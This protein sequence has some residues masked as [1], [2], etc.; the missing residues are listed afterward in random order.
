MPD[1]DGGRAACGGTGPSAGSA[2]GIDR[3]DAGCR[4]GGY[5][6][7]YGSAGP[8]RHGVVDGIDRRQA[9]GADGGFDGTWGDDHAGVYDG[10]D[11]RMTTTKSLYGSKQF[12]FRDGLGFS[13]RL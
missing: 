2:D 10:D 12:I 4:G 9:G 6:H 13:S 7:V 11:W 5:V 8:D 3:G 1:G